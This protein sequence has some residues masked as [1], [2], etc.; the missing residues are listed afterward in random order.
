V[1][2]L[3][4]HVVVAGYGRVGQIICMML[5]ARQIPY[6][7]LDFDP[8]LVNLGKE[9]G[10]NVAFGNMAALQVLDAAGVGRAAALVITLN[11]P[12]PTRNLVEAIRSLYPGVPIFARALDMQARDDLSRRGVTEAVPI[13][14]EGGLRLGR[15]TLQAIGVPEAEALELTNAFRAEDYRAVRTCGQEG[16]SVASVPAAKVGAVAPPSVGGA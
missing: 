16:P 10:H 13:A 11:A 1:E 6:L 4:R 2:H 9:R 8:R 5:H 3:D 14:A 12:G 7:A 15:V